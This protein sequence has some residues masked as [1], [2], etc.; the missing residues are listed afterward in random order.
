LRIRREHRLINDPESESTA[1]SRRLVE[2]L[3][4][5][6]SSTHFPRDRKFSIRSR[7]LPEKSWRERRFDDISLQIMSGIHYRKEKQPWQI[8]TR[9]AKGFF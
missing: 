7:P 3:I 4:P 8:V 5:E 1:V 2:I 9:A 6:L